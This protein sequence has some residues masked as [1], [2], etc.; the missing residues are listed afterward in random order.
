MPFDFFRFPHFKKIKIIADFLKIKEF[1]RLLEVKPTAFLLGGF[2]ALIAAFF[3]GVSTAI[4]IP[5]TNGVIMMNFEFVKDLPFFGYI[6]KEASR[7]FY[8]DATSILVLL[9]AALLITAFLSNILQYFSLL[10]ISYQIRHL[11][12]NMRKIIFSRYLD[13]GKMFFDRD[14]QGSIQQVLLGFSSEV[15]ER[16]NGVNTAINYIFLILAFVVVMFIISWK[17]TILTLLIAPLF[18]YSTLWLIKKIKTTSNVYAEVKDQLA[19]KVA[20]TLFCIPLVKSYA[21]EGSER[22]RFNKISDSVSKLEFSMDKK[23]RLIMPLQSSFM[24]LG[25]MF[26]LAAVAYFVLEKGQPIAGFLVYLY[27]LRR[28]LSPFVV[29]SSYKGQLASIS[30]PLNSIS[31]V[32]NNEDKFIIADGKKE[33]GGLRNFIVFKNLNFYYQKERPILKNFSLTLEKGKVTALIGQTG[34]GKTTVINLFMRFYECPPEAILIDGVDI[35]GF[36]I[37]SLMRHIALVSQECFLLN[38]TLREN[39]TYG[40]QREVSD[41]EIF[42]LLKKSRLR[43]F[44]MSLPDKLD[45]L[46]GDRGVKLSGGEKQRI[47]IARAMLKG[48]EI[49]ILDEATSSLDSTTERLV[50][51]AINEIIKD[52]TVIVIAHR[53]STIRHADK[54]AVIENGEVV[55]Q[56]SLDE[57]LNKQ[58]KFHKYWQEQVFY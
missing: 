41:E 12:N 57:L 25:M 3:E 23:A 5:I 47:S 44:V 19:R 49:L 43:D 28:I 37:A 42:I 55:E 11:V 46:I 29:L 8:I 48:A 18:Y 32:L 1:F 14:S 20:N 24:L 21:N 9:L 22:S 31:E 51:E 58:G 33:F 13:F 35:R 30:G 50:Q 15:S 34:A 45:T 27:C 39:I 53:L 40:M 7:Y 4:L 52:K 10:T 17:L 2:L 6:L 26:L 36:K 54:I 56:G 38:E 16:L